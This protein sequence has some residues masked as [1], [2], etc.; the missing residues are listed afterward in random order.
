MPRDA[1]WQVLARPPEAACEEPTF[2]DRYKR[3]DDIE[4]E[5][6]QADREALAQ[7]LESLLPS[8]AEPTRDR[9]T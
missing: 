1:H 9:R 3:R 4:L 8:A 6:H 7:E 5:S 2:F